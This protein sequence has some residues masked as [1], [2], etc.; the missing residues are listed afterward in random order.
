[1]NEDRKRRGMAHSKFLT[2]VAISAL[3]LGSGNAMAA[4][5]APS[6][7]PGITEQMQTITING[8]VEDAM[9]P[10]I[11]GQR[12]FPVGKSLTNQE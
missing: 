4:D 1:M 12:I 9:G 11:G 2:A 5:A 7:V 6:S 3:F 8:L 10:V